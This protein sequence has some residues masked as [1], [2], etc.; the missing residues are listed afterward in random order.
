MTESIFTTATASS[1]EVSTTLVDSLIAQAR[2]LGLT[3]TLRLATVITVTP[4]Q[5]LFDGDDTPLEMTSMIGPI[6]SGSRIYVIIIPRSGNFVVGRVGGTPTRYLGANIGTA[7]GFA[8]SSTGTEVAFA[9]SFWNVAEPTFTFNPHGFFRL[10]AELAP[11][12][13]TATPK[14]AIWRIRKGQATTTGTVLGV[15]YV[16]MAAPFANVGFSNRVFCYVRN[17]SDSDVVT[18]LSMTVQASLGTG[19]SQIYAGD[20]GSPTFI[21]VKEVGTIDDTGNMVQISANIAL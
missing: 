8:A 13:S 11:A 1:A 10:E 20:S 6:T 4:L 3:W 7:T 14:S 15:F 17:T 9:S 18:K 12:P 19:A 5:A 21:A 2:A 16:T